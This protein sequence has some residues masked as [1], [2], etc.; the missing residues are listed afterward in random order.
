MENAMPAA[1]FVPYEAFNEDSGLRA[2]RITIHEIFR[3]SRKFSRMTMLSCRK[4][5]ENTISPRRIRRAR[6][7]NSPNFV[8]FVSFVVKTLSHLVAALPR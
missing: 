7:T 3:G 2:L 4:G 6:I 8:L 1:C 5:R